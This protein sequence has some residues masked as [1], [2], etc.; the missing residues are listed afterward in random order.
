MKIVETVDLAEGLYKVKIPNNEIELK[1]TDKDYGY[2]YVKLTDKKHNN[3]NKGDYVKAY[4]TFNKVDK[5][6]GSWVIYMNGLRV[7]E[8]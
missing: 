2:V 6:N 4:G 8:K 3:A 7:I 5:N 1:L